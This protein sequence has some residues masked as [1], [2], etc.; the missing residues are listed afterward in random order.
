MDIE[1]ND[2]G[3]R[4]ML[5]AMFGRVRLRADACVVQACA[6]AAARLLAPAGARG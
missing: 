1:L 5:I 3:Q 4:V 2:L 6:V